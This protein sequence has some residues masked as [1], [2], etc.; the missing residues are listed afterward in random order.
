MAQVIVTVSKLD[1]LA[2]AVND[3]TNA[4]L[5]L[6][7][8]Q[9]TTALNNLVIQHYYVGSSTPSSSLGNNGDI[10]LQTSPK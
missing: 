1:N 4:T 6:T 9:M 10:Y 7:I 5:P 2:E 8:D 3:V